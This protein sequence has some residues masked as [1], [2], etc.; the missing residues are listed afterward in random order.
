VKKGTIKRFL[1]TLVL[2][3]VAVILIGLVIKYFQGGF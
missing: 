1:I 2:S 3:T